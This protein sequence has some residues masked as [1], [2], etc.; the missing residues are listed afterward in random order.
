MEVNRLAGRGAV[1]GRE[2][3]RWTHI[4]SGWLERESEREGE[5]VRE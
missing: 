4:H 3:G 2:R 5:S 1:A